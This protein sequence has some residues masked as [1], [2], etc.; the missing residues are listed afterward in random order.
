MAEFLNKTGLSKVLENILNVFL[1]RDL[2]I[3]D[4]EIDAICG[5]DSTPAIDLIAK[6]RLPIVALTGDV[7]TMD[8]DNAVTLGYT[9]KNMTGTCTCK[10]QGSSSIRYPKKNYTIKF[11]QSFEAKTGWGIHNKYVLKAN[12]VDPSALRNVYGAVIWGEMVRTRPNADTRLTALPNGGAIDGFFVWVTLNGENI[13][14]YS[15]TIPKDDWLFGMTGSSSAEGYVCADYCALDTPVTGEHSEALGMNDV[16]V[17]Y[18]AGDESALIASLNSVITAIN[19]VQSESDLAALEAVVDIDSVIDYDIHMSLFANL[20]GINR[21]YIMGTY[22]GTKWFMST[23]D[24][25]SIMGNQPLPEEVGVGEGL[26]WANGYPSFVTNLSTT[27]KLLYVVRTYYASRIKERFTSLRGWVLNEI[28]MSALL[29]RMAYEI[30]D[31]AVREENR[32]W[33]TRLGTHTG[34]YQYLADY[35][36]L[37][38]P[39]L[40]WQISQM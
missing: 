14:L 29:H 12:W 18:A 20:D 17:E 31:I 33:P 7:S 19:G 9:Y 26:L 34:N 23:Y 39:T 4:D 11:D 36:R 35:M 3:T 10:W 5:A 15:F 2:V 27:N 28:N 16:K 38:F 13:G 40:D 22:D 32:L 30:P 37:R 24:M 8:K 1:P 25:D 21:N 6:T